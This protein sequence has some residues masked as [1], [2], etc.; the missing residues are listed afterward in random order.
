MDDS[1]GA[2][3]MWIAVGALGV[4]FW[5]A[6]T[7]VLKAFAERISGKHAGD[8]RIAELEARLAALE[9]RGFTTGEVEQAYVRIA[10]L[11]ERVDFG[12]RMLT[13]LQPAQVLRPE[14]PA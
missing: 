12:E 3:G 6:M 4:S 14:E 9:Q 5:V 11:E 13:Q 2:L 10:E 7:P 8:E 1:I